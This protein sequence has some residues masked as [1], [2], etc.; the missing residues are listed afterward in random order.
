MFPC[1]ARGSTA[2]RPHSPNIKLELA[3]PSPMPP[4]STSSHR[5]ISEQYVPS[6]TVVDLH[7]FV[8]SLVQG[9]AVTVTPFEKCRVRLDESSGT[10]RL[11]NALSNALAHGDPTDS[12]VRLSIEMHTPPTAVDEDSHA[13]RLVFKV[14]N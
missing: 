4:P 6:T 9:R 12:N 3:S 1:G 11:E 7:R 5:L 10:L 14:C 13:R 2:G 8:D